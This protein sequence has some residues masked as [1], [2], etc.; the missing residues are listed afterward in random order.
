MMVVAVVDQ[1]YCRPRT[2]IYGRPYWCS[3]NTFQLEIYV[4]IKA[5]PLG[6]SSLVMLVL[7]VVVS[8]YAC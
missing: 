2:N 5:S 1:R 6:S 4:P 8:I 3:R 7:V